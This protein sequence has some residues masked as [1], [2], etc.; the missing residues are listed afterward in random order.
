VDFE[1][2]SADRFV[3]LGPS[4][5]GKTDA[6]LNTYNLLGGP[7]TF[8]VVYATGRFVT[9]NPK[10]VA[11]FVAALDEADAWIAAHPAEAAKL[12][13]ASENRCSRAAPPDRTRSRVSDPASSRTCSTA[14]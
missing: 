3:V 1:V 2:C 7:H 14:R 12:Y 8:N 13:A 4:G 10:T 5:C 6:L 9:D 11:A